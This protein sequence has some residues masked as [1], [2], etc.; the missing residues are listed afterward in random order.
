MNQKEAAEALSSISRTKARFAA[1]F[2]EIPFVRHALFGLTYAILIGSATLETSASFIGVAAALALVFLQIRQ[3]RS[4][5]GVFVNGYRRGKTLP[6]SITLV[7]VMVGFILA[8]IHAA[9]ADWPDLW[10]AGLTFAGFAIATGAS[11]IWQ[12][13]YIAELREDA[14]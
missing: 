9:D 13:I 11:M 8:A 3:D 12:R 5:Y 1:G 4:R 14:R 2:E 6:L 7:I 10:K